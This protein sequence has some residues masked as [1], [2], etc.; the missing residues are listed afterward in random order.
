MNRRRYSKFMYLVACFIIAISI[1][2]GVSYAQAVDLLVG[3]REPDQVL[4]YHG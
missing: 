3:S 1:P 4:R 2:L